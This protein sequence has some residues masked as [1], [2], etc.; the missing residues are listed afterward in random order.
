M[1]QSCFRISILDDKGRPL[2]LPVETIGPIE[3][4]NTDI[5]LIHMTDGTVWKSITSPTAIYDAI[6][7]LRTELMTAITG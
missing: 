6:E 7:T 2:I 1:I 3:L 4:L 5:T